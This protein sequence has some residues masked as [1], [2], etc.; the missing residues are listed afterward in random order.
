MKIN[1]REL[2]NAYYEN[3]NENLRHFRG[4]PGFLETWVH[5]EDHARS[6]L[7]ILDLAQ[8]EGVEELEIE[9]PQDI[10]FSFEWLRREAAS[11][12]RVELKNSTLYFKRGENSG[13][14]DI[15][16]SVLP[17]YRAAL[18][19]A[20]KSL[21]HA[22]DGNL[23]PAPGE[24]WRS[25]CMDQIRLHLRVNSDGLITA[26]RHESTGIYRPL[27]DRFAAL[28]L[29]RPLQEGAEHGVIRL[30]RALRSPQEAAPVKG[31]VTPENSDPLFLVPLKLIRELVAEGG[32]N[33]WRD[34]L[35]AHWLSLPRE[36]KEKKAAEALTQ[37]LRDLGVPDP[38]VELVEVKNDRRF[39]V[40]YPSSPANKYWHYHLIDLERALRGRLG[41]E[42]ELQL[43][44]I[45]DRNKRVER[46]KRTD[47]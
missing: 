6:L 31:V 11:L 2:V 27:L 19:E 29:Q 23:P 12:G 4:G 45:A 18:L 16:S 36:D 10:S 46:T 38:G 22:L 34:P 32:R 42:L 1:Y 5:D 21:T 13:P 24:T 35:P 8:A 28:L 40:T 9:L 47:G 3:L 44:D 7:A 33:T 15:F 30:E 43:E 14:E 41:F 26:A 25:A 37:T 20:E 39:V 17:A